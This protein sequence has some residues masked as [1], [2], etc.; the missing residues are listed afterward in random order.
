M[1]HI[2]GWVDRRSRLGMVSVVGE[3]IDGMTSPVLGL[4]AAAAAVGEAWAG[5]LPPFGAVDGDASVEVGQFSDA[6]LLA[7]VGAVGALT[8]RAEALGA[9]LAAEVAKR[10]P[11]GGR[12]GNLARTE[13]F[14]S[15][16]RL[17]AASRGGQVGRAVE[18]VKVGQGTASRRTLGGEVLPAAHPHVAAALH[19]GTISVDA[20]QVIMVMLDRVAPRANLVEVEA[21]E[22]VLTAQAAQFPLHQL[23]RLVRHAEARLD[24]GGIA[25]RE[26]EQRA[27][28]SLTLRQDPTGMF[29]LK[30]V[31][32]PE[33]GA[34]IKTVFDAYVA[35]R[36]RKT[37]GH[38]HPE[39][40]GTTGATAGAAGA[41]PGAGG[42]GEP[43]VPDGVE[44]RTIAQLQADA[45]AD[46]ARHVLACDTT[47]PLVPAVTMVVRIDLADLQGRDGGAGYATIDGVDHPISA[48]AARRLACD[49]GLIPAVFGGP[50][51]PLDLG[52]RTRTFTR[53]QVLALWERDGGCALCGQTTFVEAHHIAW[54]HRDHGTTDL[55]NGV[56]LCSR[57]HH[58]IHRDSWHI[59]VSETGE[60]SFTPPRTV[61]PDRVPR[62]ASPNPRR[63]SPPPATPPSRPPDR[64]DT[65][66]PPDRDDTRRPLAGSSQTMPRADRPSPAT[67]ERRRE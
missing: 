19:A 61:D 20:A 57:C 11:V 45:L 49:A 65:R 39:T 53:A 58:L 36:L 67:T 12:E 60:V 38:N 6:G 30:G 42:V 16:G 13:G 43:S 56:L 25:P 62:P 28:R 10:S 24:P 32:D 55:S 51:L 9:V 40:P 7:V 48:G 21:M 26:E 17:I 15:P 23:E 4:Q 54:W 41:T 8:R 5:A 34:P 1:F 2:F 52:R 33:T 31:L 47:V 18:L 14:A 64:D 66:R 46:V 50:S 59:K 29:H 3:T 27:A 22:E 44:T 35:A 37:R 63:L